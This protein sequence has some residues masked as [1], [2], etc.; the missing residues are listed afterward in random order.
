LSDNLSDTRLARYV[1]GQSSEEEV[2][3]VRAWMHGHP[4]RQA[5]VKSLERV[6]LAATA[7]QS[8]RWDTAAAWQRLSQR[9]TAMQGTAPMLVLH[10]SGERRALSSR[11][12]FRP[13]TFEWARLAIAAG[14]AVA[15]FGGFAVW[16]SHA[17][18]KL[19][20]AEMPVRD[21][22]TRRGQQ[23][24]V[25]LSDG[26]HV[27]LGVAS[28]LRFPATFGTR[29]DVYLDG[30]A[31]FDVEHDTARPFSVHTMHGT[32]RDLGTRFNVR[33]YKGDREREIEV[34][35]AQGVVAL[36]PRSPTTPNHP[37]RSGTRADSMASTVILRE[38]DL[39]R[40]NSNGDIST[41]HDVDVAS[42]LAWTRGELVF[43]NTPMRDVLPALARW[44]DAD[45][46]VADSTLAAYPITAT[47]TGEQ[48]TAA[49]ELL[50][51]ALNARIEHRGAAI[52]FRRRD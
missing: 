6:W 42:Y 17:R 27:R 9:I 49:M 22:T 45:V 12:G 2:R 23:A 10:K 21:I 24:D 48:F 47:L 50:A 35:V 8:S 25:Y 40:I 29:R 5:Q 43:R 37:V 31:Y 46:R 36:Q 33:A 38:S 14:I 32:V 7:R 20:A 26:T 13:P 44:Y 3:E 41:R 15:T 19:A 4:D 39:A 18:A 1:A 30:E 34:V 51:N 28:H 52:I 16:Q 11:R